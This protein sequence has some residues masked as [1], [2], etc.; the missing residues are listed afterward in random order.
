MT[1]RRQHWYL[2]HRVPGH[3]GDRRITCGKVIGLN[4]ST[5]NKTV[6]RYAKIVIVIKSEH[7]LDIQD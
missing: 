3:V 7:L 4:N 2:I 5:T 1:T 6:T